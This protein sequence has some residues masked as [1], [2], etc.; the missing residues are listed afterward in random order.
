[1]GF[2]ID[3]DNGLLTKTQDVPAP[4]F[5]RGMT[6]ALGGKLLLVAGQSKTQLV[7]YSVQPGGRLEATGHSLTIGFPRF[8][9]A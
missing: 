6:L 9:A 4:A 8:P 7:S 1:M 3:Q 2:A 5:P